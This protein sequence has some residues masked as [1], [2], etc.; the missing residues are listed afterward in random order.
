MHSRTFRFP[1]RALILL[2][3][4]SIML[5]CDLP[6][7]A[8]KP[9]TPT[10]T[11]LVRLIRESVLAKNVKS[12]SQEPIDA[13]NVFD[14]EQPIFHVVL[15]V[16]DAPAGSVFKAVWLNAADNTPLGETQ[17][18]AEGTR[19][20]TL[21]FKPPADQLP[22]GAYKVEVYS[23]ANLE[24]TLDFSVTRAQPTPT[25]SASKR[26]SPITMAF[27][28]DDVSGLERE[29]FQVVTIFKPTAI[30]YTVLRIRDAPANTKLGVTWYVVD[31]GKAAPANS[32]VDTNQV[33][34]D[35]TRYIKFTLT[36]TKQWPPGTYRAEIKVNDVLD[37]VI[38]YSVK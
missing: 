17:A 13:T 32:M 8:G 26:P 12:D 19:R 7:V 5:A 33:T 27:L 4:G 9:P 20:I 22:P 25:L 14:S 31:A 35:G 16:A 36:P 37:Q 28:T 38:P 15:T 21:S 11:P 24:R 18:R 10:P 29:Q 23:N 3:L 30:I 1:A 6:F 34:T 2:L